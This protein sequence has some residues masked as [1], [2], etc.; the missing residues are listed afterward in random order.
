MKTAFKVVAGAALLGLGTV[1][2]L[3]GRSG[4]PADGAPADEGPRVRL[5]VGLSA[6]D[7]EVWHHLDEGG[8]FLPLRFLQALEDA[9]T[10]AS[11]LAS[12]P[13]Y[14]LVADPDDP[15]GLPI[16][17][18]AGTLYG[19]PRG[20]L[21]VGVNCAACHSGLYTFRGTSMVIDGAPNLVDFE[22][23]FAELTR[24]AR[25]TIEDPVELLRLARR[26][27]EA[28]RHMPTPDAFFALDEDAREAL[29]RVVDAEEGSRH[30]PVRAHLARS[31]HAAYHAETDEQAARLLEGA[32]D[33]VPVSGDPDV[34]PHTAGLV[35][36]LGS[37]LRLLRRRVDRLATI[38]DAFTR[39]TQ[40]GPGRADSFDAIWNLL[41]Q[42]E[43][44][45]A[46][47]APVSIPHLFGYERFHWVHWDGN[48][49][50]V[51][52]RDYAQA[53]ALGAD[54]DPATGRSSVLPQNVMALESVAR[55]IGAPAW[56]EDVLGAID[57]GL[58]AQG[59]QIYAREC[60]SCHTGERVVPVAEVGTDAARARLFGDLH[61]D[62]KSYGEL[63]TE[64]ADR[65][66]GLSFAEHGVS[67]A[68]VAAVRRAAEPTW[69]VT[70]GYRVRALDG[71]WA[72]PP[73]LHNG[74]VPTLADLLEPPEARPD[75]F[76]VGR[77]Y[78]PV[79]VGVDARRQPQSGWMFRT[80]EPGNDNGG[81]VYG[82]ELSADQKRA[83]IEYLKTL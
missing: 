81:H 19:D 15:L 20:E 52:A 77:E 50:T 47:T 49:N 5:G 51:M 78:D 55:G 80:G 83:L 53:I 48:T 21:L 37:D 33:G 12:M 64:L 27:A 13:R 2:V 8:G 54:F 60:A 56:P 36:R 14:G 67:E 42:A 23:L 30:A 22:A 65:V 32:A 57:R 28:G 66:M 45:V 63:L 39:E 6:E 40:A 4:D 70:N 59:A 68:E 1:W 29:A 62:G 61:K 16:G 31:L 73:Y 17:F 69:R 79:K 18:T 72:S 58:A 7:A 74:S 35:S 76:L 26:M 82:T 38:H 71:I 11:F 43:A 46:M 9:E 75:S 44:P 10:G 3:A 34:D 25:R 41:V 24:S